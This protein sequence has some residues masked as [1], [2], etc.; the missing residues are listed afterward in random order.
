MRVS[1][2]CECAALYVFGLDL[3]LPHRLHTSHIGDRL[4]HKFV[5]DLPNPETHRR[6]RR[7]STRQH[8]ACMQRASYGPKFHTNLHN[9]AQAIIYG[10][11][12]AHWDVIQRRNICSL[13]W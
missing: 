2:P 6:P 5:N 11:A 8:N 1:L 10:A 9:Y 7:L 13:D 4:S 3:M 12:S